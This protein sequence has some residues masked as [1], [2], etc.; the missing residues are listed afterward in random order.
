MLSSFGGSQKF[1]VSLLGR[2]PKYVRSISCNFKM[3]LA[4]DRVLLRFLSRDHLILPS[5]SAISR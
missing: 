2:I 5:A 4:I 1:V 3:H